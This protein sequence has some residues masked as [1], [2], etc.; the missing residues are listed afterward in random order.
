MLKSLAFDMMMDGHFICGLKPTVF[1]LALI[2]YS[3]S[4]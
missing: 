3:S 1:V 2:N 4:S